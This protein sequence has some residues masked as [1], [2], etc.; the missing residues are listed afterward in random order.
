MAAGIFVRSAVAVAGSFGRS[1]AEV[2]DG[3][4]RELTLAANGHLVRAKAI[5]STTKVEYGQDENGN[6]R[7]TVIVDYQT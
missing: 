3:K 2:V 6:T 4:L 7:V 5:S 1:E